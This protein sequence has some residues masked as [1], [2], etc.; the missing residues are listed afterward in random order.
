MSFWE[1]AGLRRRCTQAAIGVG[2]VFV[3]A[4]TAVQSSAATLTVNHVCYVN[5]FTRTSV[6]QA[7]MLVT[8][9]GY[10]PGDS[11]TI[12]S[13]DGSINKVLQ[14]TPAGTIDATIGAPT[15]FLKLPS[16]KPLALIARDFSTSSG[17]ITAATFLKV[18][19]LAVATVP[20]MARPSRKV[21]WYFSGF[22]TGR[23]VYGHYTRQGREVARARF[24]RAKGTCG[25]L[26][27]RAP[28]FP[29]GHQRYRSYGLQFDDSQ[30]YN[31]HSSPRIVT[32]LGSP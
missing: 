28:F 18:A 7:P 26:Q 24:G 27:V 12:T 17:T 10:V 21:T 31:R 9:S 16:S 13:S 1:V 32:S 25:L 6:R 2:I 23:Y 14:A 20:A 3:P 19:N 11:V 8:G 22:H 30:H 15:P 29:G 5:K 4:V